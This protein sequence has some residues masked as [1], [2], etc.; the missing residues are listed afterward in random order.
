MKGDALDDAG[1][2]LGGGPAV[3]DRGVHSWDFILPRTDAGLVIR[4]KKVILREIG[5]R[6]GSGRLGRLRG[7]RSL[8]GQS[9][10]LS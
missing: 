6:R 9:E 2:L 7:H 8:C 10:G 5:C 3:W 4:Q 1:D